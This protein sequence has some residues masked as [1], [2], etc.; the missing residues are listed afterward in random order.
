[1]ART[2]IQLLLLGII[3]LVVLAGCGKNWGEIDA[4]G[5]DEPRMELPRLPMAQAIAASVGRLNNYAVFE[6]EE[7]NGRIAMTTIPWDSDTG[8][9]ERQT[10]RTY[11]T[12]G[13]YVEFQLI[14]QSGYALTRIHNPRNEATIVF[15]EPLL[16]APS[17]IALDEPYSHALGFEG[18]ARGWS[19]RRGTIT[20][21]TRYLG[22]QDVT[23]P[24]GHVANCARLDALVRIRLPLG[25][26]LRM[27][28]RQW[29]HPVY[30]DVVRDIDGRISWSMIGVRTFHRRLELIE[31]AP[32][33]EQT[34]RE[35]VERGAGAK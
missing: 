28:H 27:N 6:G 33:D 25:F 16:V 14:P 9:G 30:G 21:T 26:A 15:D 4:V 34:R 29:L 32:L 19:R 11:E 2:P 23:V 31:T 18:W 5:L 7:P 10:W 24:L 22:L 8:D 1:M 35:M 13:S 3:L 20:V 17:V 12:K